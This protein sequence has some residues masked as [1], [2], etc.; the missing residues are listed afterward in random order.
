GDDADAAPGPTLT[1]G[2]LAT[3]SYVVTN[4]GNIA[5]QNIVVVDNNGTPGTGDDI[6]L[7][8][9]SGDSN[10]NNLLDLGETWTY[11]T[12]RTVAAGQQAT[13]GS[14][15]ASDSLSQPVD[16]SNNGNY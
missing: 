9:H 8:T 15:S 5:L 12:T 7:V 6:T 16:S 14:V 3:L 11:M 10:S 13:T 4:T 2:S 1:V